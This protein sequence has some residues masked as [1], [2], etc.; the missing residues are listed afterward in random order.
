MRAAAADG[1]PRRSLCRA[2]RTHTR[3]RAILHRWGIL[4][5]APARECVVNASTDRSTGQ[6]HGIS[7]LMDFTHFSPFPVTS[8]HHPP[9]RRRRE[10]CEP[11]KR[12]SESSQ[13]PSRVRTRL[14]IPPFRRDTEM[15]SSTRRTCRNLSHRAACSMSLEA[16]L[17]VSE[18]ICHNLSSQL[19]SRGLHSRVFN[20]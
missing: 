15:R 20:R 5:R 7:P 1:F 16:S 19:R 17:I 6:T 12:L 3:T 4:R 8:P 10:R 11:P 13:G 2:S 18:F 14:F 9:R